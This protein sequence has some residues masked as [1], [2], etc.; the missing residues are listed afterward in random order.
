MVYKPLQYVWVELCFCHL[1]PFIECSPWYRVHYV[2]FTMYINGY[3]LRIHGEFNHMFVSF[4]F[5][6]IAPLW[7]NQVVGT[8]KDIYDTDVSQWPIKC[9]TGVLWVSSEPSQDYQSPEACTF[10]ME[11][12]FCGR[13]LFTNQLHLLYINFTISCLLIHGDIHI[14]QCCYYIPFG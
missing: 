14:Q 7:M 13:T 4:C 8:V 2:E 12:C 1:Y 9:G 6:G 3:G 11:T 10:Q 5:K